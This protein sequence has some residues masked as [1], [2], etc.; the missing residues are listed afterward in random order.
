MSAPRAW[1]TWRCCGV[2]TAWTS[3]SGSAAGTSTTPR[4]R[5]TPNP[6]SVTRRTPWC[7]LTSDAPQLGAIVEE[8]FPIE[9]TTSLHA[10]FGAADDADLADRAGKMAASTSAFGA[11]VNV[12][13]VPTS[14]YIMRNPF[15]DNL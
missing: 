6:R 1:R 13:T 9:A 3:E 8:L 15:G 5:S 10:F 2:P 7:A 11:N 12:D 14:R 4:S